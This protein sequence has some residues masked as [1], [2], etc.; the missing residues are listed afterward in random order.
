MNP[1]LSELRTCRRPGDGSGPRLRTHYG[2]IERY[3][4]FRPNVERG[5]A[6]FRAR[7]LDVVHVPYRGT[8]SCSSMRR[9]NRCAGSRTPPD[10]IRPG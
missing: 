4:R 1:P 8:S 6:E 2:H 10:P 5:K 3:L 9:V 7:L